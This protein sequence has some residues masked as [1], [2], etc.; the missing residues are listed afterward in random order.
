[1]LKYKVK[2]IALVEDVWEQKKIEYIS[3]RKNGVGYSLKILPSN[4]AI[5]LNNNKDDKVCH[6]NV[7]NSSINKLVNIVGEDIVEYV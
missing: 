1:M 3:N 7:E 5:S 4:D 2:V 6:S